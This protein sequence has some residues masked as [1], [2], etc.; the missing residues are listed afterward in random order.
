MRG[1]S[2]DR[3]S[4]TTPKTDMPDE[5]DPDAA[6]FSLSELENWVRAVRVETLES[7]PPEFTVHVSLWM[8]SP[9]WQLTVDEIDREKGGRV[10]IRVTGERPEGMVASVMTRTEVGVPLGHLPRGEILLDVWGRMST[11]EEH[12][13]RGMALLGG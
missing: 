11:T 5:P 8:P 7:D 4:L 9:G 3:E 2:M 1:R 6:A 12:R 13:R 10:L